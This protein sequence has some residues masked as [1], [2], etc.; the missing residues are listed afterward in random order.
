[1]FDN[2]Q[3]ER[4]RHPFEPGVL[5]DYGIEPLIGFGLAGI[6][7]YQ[8]ESNAPVAGQ[9]FDYDPTF[10]MLLQ[11]HVIDTWRAKLNTPN[12]YHVQLPNLNR[13][14]AA[15]RDGQRKLDAIMAV[16][17]DIG[18]PTNVHPSNKKDVGERLA[19]QALY[20]T[21]KQT[22]TLP[23]GPVPC[24]TPQ[25]VGS[26][27]DLRFIYTAGMHAGK[28]FELAGSD[29]TYHPASVT[30]GG[31]I[32]RISSPLVSNPRS[33]RYAWA[34]NPVV[35]FTNETDIP[36]SP[37]QADVQPESF[38]SPKPNILFIAV[39]DLR[40]ELGC[41]GAQHVISPNIDRLAQKGLIFDRAYCQASLC[42]PSR[43]SLMSGFRPESTGI[44]GNH[45]SFRKMFPGIVTLPQY[46][47]TKGYHAVGIGK[48]Y[49]GPFPDGSSI[50]PW[51]TFDDPATWSEPAIRFGPQYY[52]NAEGIRHA[53]E[54]YKR[55]YK[56]SN[57]SPDEWKK[58]LT[59]GLLTE[60]S[61][62]PENQHYDGKVA[63]ATIA[64][65]RQLKDQPFFLAAGFIKPHS[66]WIAPKKYFDLYDRAKI[67]LA[68]NPAFP[69]GTPAIAGHSSSEP[70][71]YP[72]VPKKGDY[73]ESVAR[74]LKHGYLACVSFID[75]QIGR[76]LDE[77]K[78]LDLDKNTIV[79]LWGDHGYHLGEQSLWGKLTN[80][81]N[82]ARV[83][84]MIYAP[85]MQATGKRSTAL[86]ELLD[87]YPSLCELA[88][89]PI[90]AEAQGTSFAPLLKDP[91]LP[92]KDGAYTIIYRGKALGHSVRTAD[93]RY[94]EWRDGEKVI[95]RELYDHKSD[96]L[97]TR[98]RVEDPTYGD[99]VQFCQ[100]VLNQKVVKA[101]G[102]GPATADHGGFEGL[103]PGSFTTLDS[104]FGI[105]KTTE[106]IAQVDSAHAKTGS[107]CLQLMGGTSTVVEWTVPEHA[108]GML[109]FAAERWT[110]RK[111][112]S[113]RIEAQVGNTWKE[114]YSGDKTI[115]VGRS[116][117]NQVEVPLPDAATHLR[118]S[119]SS[120]EKT[121]ILIDDI[122]IVP[123]IPMK[124]L[125]ASSRQVVAPVLIGK[126]N[127]PVLAIDVETEGRLE[128]KQLSSLTLEWTGSLPI[129][130]VAAVKLL[131]KKSQVIGTVDSAARMTLQTD[132]QLGNG[133]NTF[134]V[135]IDLKADADWNHQV[136][137]RLTSLH[138]DD[139]SIAI[140]HPSP[141]GHNRIGVALRIRGQ[142]GI[143]TTRIPGITTTPKGTLI[144]VYD[145][146]NR[147]GGDL[148]GDIDVGMS[149]STDGGRTWSPMQ[150]IMDQGDN[151]KWAYDGIGDPAILTD[152]SNGTIWVAAT[153][154]HGK[155]S[156]HGSGPGMT[157]EET[158][159]FML[160]KSEDDGLTWSKSINITQQIKDPAWNFL[161]QGPGNGI[162]LTDGTLVFPAQYKDSKAMPFSTIVYSKDHGKTWAIGTG[163]I[164]NTTEAQVVQLA[165]GALMINCRDN[166]GGARSVY[167]TRDLGKTW[168]VHP[169]NRT[170]LPEPVCNAGLLRMGDRLFFSNP[171]QTR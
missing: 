123:S 112:F 81:E 108:P 74:E 14:W 4:P 86:V 53:R 19:R 114:I 159:Q 91:D 121:G 136:D 68:E 70:R 104:G 49:H 133:P 64:K 143:H 118:F 97:E 36:A 79:V 42:N 51:D 15:F 16:T 120:P 152:T 117:L 140:K 1:W 109:T 127:N 142:D 124:I 10:A 46:F 38:G 154:S 102:A 107:Q 111:P 161:L 48:I 100:T 32:L 59:F 163:V 141:V 7:W 43:T 92:W 135:A 26:A 130:Q 11:Q 84:L 166:R 93:H 24:G 129:A 3:G 57:P 37:F 61:T 58:K 66:P 151:P 27:I 116:F 56:V 23:G 128:P 134:F 164:S 168:L 170:A 9:A 40:T 35:D 146:R 50:T 17:I 67:P 25:R 39:D 5:Y 90:P 29:G 98:N 160:A 158:G 137:L 101:P 145:N 44:Y 60:A 138:V 147:A 162:T 63:D 21:Y 34:P 73:P 88:G 126:A 144:A 169:T 153:W 6:L 131:N 95:A 103:K 13:N 72:P 139:T 155:R 87:L 30:V 54:S 33:V 75:A 77:L 83:P 71:R 28:G 156:W 96:P 85:G 94:T 89:M 149:R 82:G 125:S 18:H 171:P 20:H 165:D 99:A 22:E 148:P 105:F 80:F 41:Y 12:F 2:A 52:F 8:G 157:P 167:T 110:S 106:G 119:C 65:L 55:T 47:E 76:I 62:G 150:V 115:K 45:A 78:V 122:R 31:D 132:T 69:E 113:F